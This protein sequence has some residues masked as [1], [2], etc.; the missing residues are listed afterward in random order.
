LKAEARVA[1][2]ER[3]RDRWHVLYH[4]NHTQ[5]PDCGLCEEVRRALYSDVKKEA[6]RP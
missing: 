3:E 5:H 6:P 2:L 1:E 4:D